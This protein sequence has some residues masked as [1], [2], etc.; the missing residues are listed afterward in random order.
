M[1]K[2][3]IYT[4]FALVLVGCA[5]T[6]PIKPEQKSNIHTVTVVSLLG[7]DLEFTKVGFTA[8]NNDY[9]VRDTTNWDLDSEIKKITTETMQISSPNIKTIQVPFDQ[10]EL[11]KIYKSPGSWGDYTNISRIEPELKIKLSDSPVDAVLLVYKASEEDPIAFTSI[12]IKGYGIYYRSLPFVNP[13]LKPYALLRL[14][15]LDGKTLKPITSKYIRGIS[16][17][18]GKT[19]ISWDDQIKNNLSDSMLSDFKT[20]ISTLIKENLKTGLIDMGL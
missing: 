2:I 7:N 10:S 19:E 17:D 6:A 5:N 4:F 11:F 15:L 14:E 1:K 12:N 8:F 16:T 3:F 9:F 18:Y 20:S 13:T